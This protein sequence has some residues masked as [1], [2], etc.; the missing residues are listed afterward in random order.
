MNLSRFIKDH[1]Q[2][3]IAEW[4]TFAET[5]GPVADKMSALALRDHAKEILETIAVDITTAQDLEGQR[6][7]SKGNADSATVTVLPPCMAGCVTPATSP[8]SNSARSIVLS[9]RQSCA[10]GCHA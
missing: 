7:K 3:I 9:G 10:C 4:E 1:M 2:Q 5:L 6:Q 8:S